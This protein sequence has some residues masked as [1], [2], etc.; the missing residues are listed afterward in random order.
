MPHQA[1]HEPAELVGKHAVTWFV[2]PD[3]PVEGCTVFVRP[4]RSDGIDEN[5]TSRD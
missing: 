2:V 1:D 4:D 5:A 3:R